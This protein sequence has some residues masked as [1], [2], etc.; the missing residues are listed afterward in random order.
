M[1]GHDIFSILRHILKHKLDFSSRLDG[2]RNTL[3]QWQKTRAYK[4]EEF[5]A[6]FRETGN[7]YLRIGQFNQA[8]HFYNEALLYGLFCFYPNDNIRN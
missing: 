1:S 3:E 8:L 6:K 7:D 4:N 5:S 2:K